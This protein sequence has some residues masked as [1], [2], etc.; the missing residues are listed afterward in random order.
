MLALSEILLILI[1]CKFTKTKT[2]MYII[3]IEIKI[4]LETQFAIGSK[5]KEK[6]NYTINVH[7]MVCRVFSSTLKNMVCVC[8]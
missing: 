1:F 3:I 6:Y 4:L 5:I 8:K 2:E 7:P